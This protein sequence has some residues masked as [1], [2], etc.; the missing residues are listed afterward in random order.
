[1]IPHGRV[2]RNAKAA[3][4]SLLECSPYGVHFLFMSLTALHP[5]LLDRSLRML[6]MLILMTSMIKLAV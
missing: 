6:L 1:M 5:S 4:P 3:W 2:F